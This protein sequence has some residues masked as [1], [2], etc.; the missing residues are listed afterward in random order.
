M[1]TIQ[2]RFQP[3][4]IAIHI[5]FL[6]C[7][8]GLLEVILRIEGLSSRLAAPS[9]GSEHRQFEI[10]L[11]RLKAVDAEQG[12]IDCIFVGDSLVW[13]DLD[14]VKFGEGYHDKSGKDLNCFNF[15]VAALPAS[16]V[17]VL[18]KILV[19]EYN[20]ELII[21]GLHANSVVVAQEHKDASII[22]STPWVRYKAGD[23]DLTGWLYE[24]SYFVRYLKVLN[25]LLRFDRDA[26]TN[27]LGFLPNQLRGFDSKNG[28][29]IDINT[30]PSRTNDA[31]VN[32]FEKY[33][34][35]HIFPEN[36]EGIR[37]VAKLTDHDT[38]VIMV[39]MP[40]NRAFYAFFEK[41]EQDYSHI[42]E[43]IEGT[44]VDT[45]AFLL[46]TNG[47]TLLTDSDWWDYSHL[48]VEGAG[49]FSYWLGGK[50]GNGMLDD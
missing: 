10:Q 44:L 20:P 29:R 43:I 50:V 25:R 19:E 42:T 2:V 36:I 4:T 45:H 35:Y 30:P 31:D 7:F 3:K 8:I 49:E 24:N 23:F 21:F 28:Q 6:F 39:M 17:S 9:F 48:N 11:S 13:L 40:V 26:M 1:K 12:P 47:E 33:Y 15:G 32:G 37:D 34:Q 18:T 38:R 41:G 46:K 5:A 16:G 14:P 27:E 22:L